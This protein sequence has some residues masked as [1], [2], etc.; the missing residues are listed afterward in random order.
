MVKSCL[1]TCSSALVLTFGSLLLVGCQ[2]I[3]RQIETRSAKNAPRPTSSL[4]NKPALQVKPGSSKAALA[5]QV[6]QNPTNPAAVGKLEPPLL[7]TTAPASL[8]PDPNAPPQAPAPVWAAAPARLPVAVTTPVPVPVTVQAVPKPLPPIP[9]PPGESAAPPANFLMPSD[10]FA[11]PAPVTAA[12]TA[13]A[14][15]TPVVA[16]PTAASAAS[17]PGTSTDGIAASPAASA[18]PA[19]APAKTVYA[20]HITNKLVRTKLPPVYIYDSPTTRQYMAAGGINYQNNLDIWQ[21]FLRRQDIPYEVITSLAR[22]DSK[23]EPQAT[24]ILA[25]ALALDDAEKRHIRTFQQKGGNL[26]AT[27]LC[28]VRNEKGAWIG[29]QFMQQALQTNVVGSTEADNDDGFLIPWGDSPVSHQLP[30]GLRVW[31]ERIPNWYPLRLASPHLA[32]QITDWSR[33]ANPKKRAG[34]ISYA[35]SAQTPARSVVLGYPERLWFSADPKAFDALASDAL[36]WLMH[37]PAVYLASWPHPWR[38]AAIISINT[39]DVSE[40]PDLAFAE[41]IENLGWRATYYAL[42]ERLDVSKAFLK[43]MQARGHDVAYFG[44]RLTGFQN[45][46]ANQQNKRLETMINEFKDNEIEPTEPTGFRAP[47]DSLD[48]TTL[49]LLR[50][51]GI[52]HVVAEQGISETRLPLLSS[53]IPKANVANAKGEPVV[54]LPRTMNAPEDLL[55]DN[56]PAIAAQNTLHELELADDMASLSVIAIPTRTSVSPANWAS[57]LNGIKARKDKIWLSTAN[58]VAAWWRE[59]ER[60]KIRFD[61]DVTPALLTVEISGEGPLQQAPMLL[62][63]LPEPGRNPQL[64]ADGHN[65]AAPK[66]NPYDSLRAAIVLPKLAPGTYHWYLSF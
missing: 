49:R 42:S 50:Q 11:P 51:R 38:S 66:I 20:D 3:E 52:N 33:N 41:Q 8:L 37:Q 56:T 15:P 58:Q 1:S 22:F 19:A 27:W 36:L 31:T 64:V 13:A 45:Q 14:T 53:A 28:G 47:L 2:L 30:A 54:I 29:F 39:T 16:A 60:V 40:E 17:V 21:L 44:D 4:S 9:A 12:S 34:V 48:P 57:I 63:N 25:S 24:L 6:R 61:A 18:P 65:A 46:S 10:L 32:A 7:L 43:K 62:V 35:W 55:T 5:K 26:L 59:H 23:P